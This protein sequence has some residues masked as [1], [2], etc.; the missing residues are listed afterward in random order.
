LRVDEIGLE[1]EYEKWMNWF[2]LVHG[3]DRGGEGDLDRREEED[4]REVGR[5]GEEGWRAVGAAK[6]SEE[7]SRWERAEKCSEDED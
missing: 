4:R 1:S 5:E 3:T 2:D 7:E 6:V